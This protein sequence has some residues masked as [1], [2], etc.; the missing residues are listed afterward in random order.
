MW[1]FISILLHHSLFPVIP[2]QFLPHPLAELFSH[3]FTDSS[4]RFTHSSLLTHCLSLC[5]RPTSAPCANLPT[6]PDFPA[7]IPEAETLPGSADSPFRQRVWTFA[8]VLGQTSMLIQ[9]A[10]AQAQSVAI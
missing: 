5:L 10:M 2:R 7:E 1:I 9:S 4:P 6:L 3:S 8:F